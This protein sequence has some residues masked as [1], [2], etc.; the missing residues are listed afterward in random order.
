MNGTCHP[1]PLVMMATKGT[2]TT[3]DKD[4]TAIKSPNAFALS[5]GGS[6]SATAAMLL[7]GIIP[8]QSPVKILNANNV[9][10]FGAKLLIKAIDLIDSGAVKYIPQKEY[11]K[12]SK[13]DN[14]SLFSTINIFIAACAGI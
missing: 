7:G 1:P 13:S 2:P 4:A 11:E 14:T 8:P 9:S 12:S 3:P 10:K 6:T 5:A